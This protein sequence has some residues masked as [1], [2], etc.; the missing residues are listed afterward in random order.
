MA[1]TENTEPYYDD[2]PE[3]YDTYDGPDGAGLDDSTEGGYTAHSS[4]EFEQWF[5][6]LPTDEQQAFMDRIT[7]LS[8][9]TPYD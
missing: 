9:P 3:G 1:N 6:N 5:N 4:E 8:E 7:K 2:E